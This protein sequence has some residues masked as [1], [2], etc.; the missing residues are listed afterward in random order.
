MDVPGFSSNGFTFG[1]KEEKKN[2][3]LSNEAIGRES[4]CS[5][6]WFRPPHLL[7]SDSFPTT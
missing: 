1:I 5:F 4:T 2:I 6:S 3:M 7:N